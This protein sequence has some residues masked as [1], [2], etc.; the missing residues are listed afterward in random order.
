MG[1]C[2]VSSYDFDLAL[3]VLRST[4]LGPD[5]PSL[6]ELL[7]GRKTTLLTHIPKTPASE[8]VQKSS[9]RVRQLQQNSSI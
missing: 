5:L 7:Q 6:A 3:L 9:S 8:D 4:P 2:D 1:K